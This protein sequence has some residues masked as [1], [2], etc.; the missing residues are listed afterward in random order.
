MVQ[1]KNYPI[2]DVPASGKSRWYGGGRVLAFVYSK[3][4]GNFILRGFS[5]EVQEYLKKNYSHYFYYI[6][7]WY[8]GMSRGY[9][10]FWK[11]AV[12]LHPPEKK[13][14]RM[15]NRNRRFRVRNINT[16]M[17]LTFKRLPKRWI[18]EFDNL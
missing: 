2:I 10:S 3:S 7:F 12:S 15:N 18:P 13:S 4:N 16:K 11:D 9:W 5:N 14:R 1:N 6:S 8:S 17:E